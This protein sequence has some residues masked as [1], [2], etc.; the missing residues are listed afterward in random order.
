MPSTTPVGLKLEDL[1]LGDR[2]KYGPFVATVDYVDPEGRWVGLD[3][4]AEMNPGS[5]QL[6]Y[7]KKL[8]PR[9]RVA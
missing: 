2:V 9:R 5:I 4:D 7:M 8:S 3:N 6:K 1:Q